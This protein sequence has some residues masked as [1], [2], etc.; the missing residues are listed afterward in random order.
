M[1]LMFGRVT[2]RSVIAGTTT[3]LGWPEWQL[4]SGERPVGGRCTAGTMKRHL[5]RNGQ[6]SARGKAGGHSP[7]AEIAVMLATESQI[8]RLRLSPWSGGGSLAEVRG[9][10]R[11]AR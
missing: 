7:S 2:A 10:G 11:A 3:R 6:H 1:W 9:V 5:A 8:A 4:A